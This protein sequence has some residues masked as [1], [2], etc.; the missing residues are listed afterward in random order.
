MKSSALYLFFIFFCGCTTPTAIYLSTQRF[1]TPATEGGFLNGSAGLVAG[2]S[3]AVNPVQ[4][5]SAPPGTSGAQISPPSMWG[6]LGF[7]G[8]L[9]GEL[10]VLKM[11]DLVLQGSQA[12][13]KV[14]W[15]GEDVKEG[16]KS[17]VQFLTSGNLDYSSSSSNN[18]LTSKMT[19]Q[20]FGVSLGYCY[21]TNFSLYASLGHRTYSTAESLNQSGSITNWNDSGYQNIFA[22]GFYLPG[23]T[24][25][26]GMELSS[27]ETGWSRTSPYYEASLGGIFGVRW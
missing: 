23:E 18:T 8:L 5:L 26:L 20:D 4:N 1:Q 21:P 10:G 14:Q 25:Y 17:S 15:L 12:G 13:V 16:W 2:G 7:T 3:V 9:R 11:A 6:S 27:V 22:L 24:Y 19:G